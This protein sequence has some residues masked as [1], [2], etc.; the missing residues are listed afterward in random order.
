MFVLLIL[1]LFGTVNIGAITIKDFYVLRDF[2][3]NLIPKVDTTNY[4]S[5]ENLSSFSNNIYVN[6]NLHNAWLNFVNSWNSLMHNIPKELSN[7]V[8][9]ELLLQ[10]SP[11][12]NSLNNFLSILFQFLAI[13]LGNCL[14]IMVASIVSVGV[15]VW[16]LKS[17]NS[18]GI[19]PGIP[20]KLKFPNF[21]A[22]AVLFLSFPQWGFRIVK[23]V[24]DNVLIIFNSDYS[25]YANLSFFWVFSILSF[26][27]Y[28]RYITKSVQLTKFNTFNLDIVFINFL[29]AFG[30]FF[31][32]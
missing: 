5:I 23:F 26:V 32:Y 9:Q 18:I 3:N 6:T 31:L 27:V 15:V 22:H 2:F 30:V 25:F 8:F 19:I 12:I 4:F 13:I 7:E 20:W 14:P 11:T 16:F 17:W 29:W 10:L 24:K 21:F 28:I 1:I